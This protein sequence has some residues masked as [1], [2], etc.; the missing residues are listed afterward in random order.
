MKNMIDVRLSVHRKDVIH[1]INT[2][3]LEHMN[4][5]RFKRYARRLEKEQK[6]EK[7]LQDKINEQ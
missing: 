5:G 1:I 6:H 7:M 3:H 2:N 4:I